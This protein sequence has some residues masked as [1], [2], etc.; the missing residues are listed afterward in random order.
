MR[1]GGGAVERRMEEKNKQMHLGEE[2][3]AQPRRF[4]QCVEDTVSVSR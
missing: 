2:L 1:G 3:A 4:C